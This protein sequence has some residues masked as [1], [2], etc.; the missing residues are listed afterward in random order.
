MKININENFGKIKQNYLF[1]DIAA[2]V[3]AF[4][5]KNPEADIIRLGIGDVTL[6]L[7]EPSVRAMEAAAKEMGVKESFRGYP[8]EYGYDF[9]REAIS[10]HYASLGT[11]I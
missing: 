10:R 11:D 2:R 3:K 6:P 8:P 9:L 1:S 5:E 4:K 7:P